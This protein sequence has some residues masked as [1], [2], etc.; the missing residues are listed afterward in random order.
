VP[1][2]MK[3]SLFTTC[4]C[5]LGASIWFFR[6][7]SS[8][9]SLASGMARGDDSGKTAASPAAS[10][11]PRPKLP[12]TSPPLGLPIV[13]WGHRDFFPVIRKP[14]YV[15]AAAGDTLLL[16]TEP[17]LGVVVGTQARAYSTNQLNDHEMVIDEIAG[18]PVLVTY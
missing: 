8:D 14:V 3:W 6:S 2:W 17:V 10:D 1:R 13:N 15:S 9:S 11:P 18:V 12:E 7:R 4:C 5:C 16:D